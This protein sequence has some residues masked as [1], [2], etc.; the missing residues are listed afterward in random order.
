MENL[1]T[2]KESLDLISQM[3]NTAKNNLQKGTGKIFLLW[4]YLAAGISLATVILLK[5]LPPETRYDAF[6]L[7]FLMGAGYPF[8]YFLIRK[9][10]DE[11]LVKTYIEKL[12]NWVWI[13]FT[14]S[15]LVVV[16]GMLTDT[17]IVSFH[18]DE[19]KTGH[20]FVRWF[21]W[22]L[23][24]P[25]M[26]CLYGFALFVSGKAYQFKPLVIGGL[27]CFAASFLLIFLMHKIGVF[28]LQQLVL[29]ISAIAGFVIPGHLLNRKEKQDVQ[30]A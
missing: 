8:H 21:Q 23:L 28:P 4:G 2:E 16:M 12:M 5:V 25:I 26:L 10:S 30:G 19:F 6:Y 11:M 15:I 27:V 1:L 7:W 14:I 24:T 22:I 20:E 3:I 13:G 17:V 18:A 29:C 9:R